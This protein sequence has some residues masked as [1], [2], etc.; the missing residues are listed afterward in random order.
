MSRA[1]DDSVNLETPPAGKQVTVN[2]PSTSSLWTLADKP[3]VETQARPRRRRTRRQVPGVDGRL[4]QRHPLLQGILQYRRAHGRS[5]DLR[6]ARCWPAASPWARSLSGWQTVT[7][8]SP[9]H[10]AAGTTYVASYHTD[11]YYSANDELFHVDL[12]Q[13]TSQRSGRRRRLRLQRPTPALFPTNR[14]QQPELLGG[15]RLQ[16]W[17]PTRRRRQTTIGFSVGKNG[18]LAISF[19]ALLANDTDP[20]GDPLTVTQSATRRTEQ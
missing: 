3:P 17:I 15:R 13:R 6:P 9:V 12:H 20:N 16:R 14:R 1:V 19:A 7:F 2:L 5:V 4:R 11:G 18:T 10:I 8:S